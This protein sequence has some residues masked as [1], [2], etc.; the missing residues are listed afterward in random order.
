MD[1]ENKNFTM[2]L[3]NL[4]Y[5]S[6]LD[7]LGKRFVSFRPLSSFFDGSFSSLDDDL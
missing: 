2:L 6:I 7:F 4:L 5:T 1:N 3:G